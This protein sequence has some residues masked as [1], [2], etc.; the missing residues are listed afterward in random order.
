MNTA[1]GFESLPAYCALSFEKHSTSGDVQLML[2]SCHQ[3]AIMGARC[4]S[5]YE[6]KNDMLGFDAGNDTEID[7]TLLTV[8]LGHDLAIPWPC[9]LYGGSVS[10]L[11]CTMQCLTIWDSMCICGA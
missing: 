6:S 8:I 7:I 4:L 10:S 3:L 2:H 5:S 1:R 9:D 11:C